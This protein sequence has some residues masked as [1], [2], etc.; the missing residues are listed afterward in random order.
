MESLIAA[1]GGLVLFFGALVALDLAMVRRGV[2]TRQPDIG[3][4]LFERWWGDPA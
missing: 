2:D 1:L 3:R 4:T